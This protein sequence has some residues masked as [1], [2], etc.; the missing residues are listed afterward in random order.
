MIT[1]VDK[2]KY[3]GVVFDEFGSAG[4]HFESRL[5]AFLRAGLL[6]LS[7]LRRLPGYA[8][9]FLV[10]LWSVLVIPVSTYGVEAFAWTDEIA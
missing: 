1:A 10:Y 4:A 3:L 2:F 5:S 8:H 6:L 7:A 9:D